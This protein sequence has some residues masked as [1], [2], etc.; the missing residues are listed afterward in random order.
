MQD[1]LMTTNPYMIQNAPALVTMLAHS[2]AQPSKVTTQLSTAMLS[3]LTPE[4][5]QNTVL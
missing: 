1:N 5:L 4:R 3:I 2:Q